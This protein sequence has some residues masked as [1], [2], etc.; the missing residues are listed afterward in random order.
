MAI[1]VSQ[2]INAEI[3]NLIMEATSA[4]VISAL[5][6]AKK[7]VINHEVRRV[8]HSKVDIMKAKVCE[9]SKLLHASGKRLTA[10]AVSKKFNID[11]KSAQMYVKT[12]KV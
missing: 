12:C 4:D 1:T 5:I 8:R 11:I 6:K 2:K 7:I 9:Y 3:D 10:L